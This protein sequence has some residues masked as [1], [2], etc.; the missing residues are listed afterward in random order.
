MAQVRANALLQLA[1]G[2]E[3]RRYHWSKVMIYLD[4]YDV[5]ELE[6]NI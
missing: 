5:V 2:R 3:P 6:F 1:D 4:R